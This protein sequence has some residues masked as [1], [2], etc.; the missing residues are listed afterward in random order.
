MQIEIH[1][2]TKF[3]I[4]FIIS[5]IIIIIII[6]IISLIQLFA[7]A[8]LMPIFTHKVSHNKLPKVCGFIVHLLCFQKPALSY[9]F[10]FFLTCS[11]FGTISPLPI[12]YFLFFFFSKFPN[13]V[14]TNLIHNLKP[15]LI[16]ELSLEVLFSAVVLC[17]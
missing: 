9:T 7:L 16:Y 1:A 11:V 15:S 3:I 10:T 14:S 17:L 5:I 8:D 6:I 2:S 13:P 12:C 4:I